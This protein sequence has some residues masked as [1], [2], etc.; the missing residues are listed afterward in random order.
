MVFTGKTSPDTT[1]RHEK[2]LVDAETMNE[3][4]QQP[5]GRLVH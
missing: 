4:K 1:E 3:K 2:I 5:Y